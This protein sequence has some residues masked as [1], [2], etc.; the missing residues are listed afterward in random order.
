MRAGRSAAGGARVSGGRAARASADA[1][2]DA[3]RHNGTYDRVV[4]TATRRGRNARFRC[5]CILQTGW[6]S[7][8]PIHTAWKT[9]APSLPF[10]DRE[11]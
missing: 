3:A 9:R 10:H 5:T 8:P 6:P 2:D 7:T 1:D 11:W 4:H